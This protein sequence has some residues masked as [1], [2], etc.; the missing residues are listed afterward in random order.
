MDWAN[1]AKRPAAQARALASSL[2]VAFGFVSSFSACTS[3][4]VE[5]EF[6]AVVVPILEQRCA[7]AACHGVSA[8]EDRQGLDLHPELYLTFEL[9]SVGRIRDLD[10]AL[11][12]VKAKVDSTE[13][14]DFSSLLRKTLPV[15]QG[16]ILHFQ[17]A[18]FTSREDPEWM[19]LRDWVHS[20]TDGT[21]HADV[22]PLSNLELQ[23]RE[24]VYPTFVQKGC[25]LA[26]C[27]G[28]LNFGGAVLRAPAIPGTFSLPREAL[29][30]SYHEAVSNL[31][32]TGD[33]LRSRLLAKLLPLELGGI[34]HKGGND[35]FMASSTEERR[36]PRSA[37][38]V[39]AILQWAS[40]VRSKALSEV[41]AVSTTTTPAIVFVGGPIAPG[42][43]FSIDPFTPGTDLYRLEPPWS[44]D[45]AVNLTA[46]HHEGPADIR[47]PAVSHDGRSL[48]FTMRRSPEDAANLY[49]LGVD[50]SNLRQLT[51]D[52]AEDRGGLVNSNRSPVFGPTDG[53][54]FR[55]SGQRERIYFVSTR[56][57]Q[58]TDRGDIQ[59]WEL[60]AIDL[61]GSNLERLTFT[62]AAEVAPSFLATGE[63]FGTVVY[64]IQRAATGGL[65][66]ALFRFPIDHNGAHH[67]QPEA[68]PHFGTTGVNQVY[69]GLRELVDGRAVVTL[70]DEG[71]VWRGGQ[72]AV[73]DRQLAVDTPGGI[74]LPT[75]VPGFRHALSVLTP[76]AA[77]RGDSLGGLWRDP[78]PWPEGGFLAV[79][80]PGP[81]DLDQPAQRL[82]GALVRVELAEDRETLKPSVGRV[83]TL[84]PSSSE[85]SQPVVVTPRP[86]EDELHERVWDSGSEPA[87]LVHSGAQVI[88]A[89]LGH[90]PPVGARSLRD[91]LAQLRVV[92]PVSSLTVEAVPPEKT[93]SGRRG[94]TSAS[95]TGRTPLYAVGEVPLAPD[96]SCLVELP[97]R[98]PMRLA[99]LDRRGMSV[100]ADHHHWSAPKAK[101]RFPVG[102]ASF[103]YAARCA[104]C[105]GSMDGDPGQVLTPPVDI[106]TQASVTLARFEDHDRRRPLD[107]QH[108]NE[109]SSLHVDFRRDLEPILVTRCATVGCHAGASPAAGLSLTAAPTAFY[110]DAYES[111]LQHTGDTFLYVDALGQRARASALMERLLGAELDAPRR[112]SGV[113]PPPG[114]PGLSEAEQQAFARWIEL[115]AA[116]RGLPEGE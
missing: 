50:G 21:E 67:L 45:A 79:H 42:G 24:T 52:R 66:G 55:V 56:T 12:S 92:A 71:N 95:L 9:D 104:G 2:S 23:Y 57:R 17:R 4:S 11:A 83:T 115:G 80:V 73:L 82:R 108:V 40:A 26:T 75:S 36:D 100:G 6:E 38:E 61:D 88:E 25:V 29:R 44:P 93:R 16:G 31:A 60:F 46:A 58:W 15:V 32:P 112:L 96:G 97:A 84:L 54:H 65:R 103:A 3:A 62:P 78:S 87:V 89:L 10:A 94:A 5:A 35:V 105:H 72:L 90:L 59:D 53:T 77:R 110:T 18:V 69:L 14:P 109:G 41:G 81:L 76:E 98:V 101:E 19:T 114:H 99:F 70:L 106:L 7:S 33:L 34:P 107:P 20:V 22:P 43:P 64:T 27:H 30:A 74:D 1:N 113:C 111:L 102:I 37:P 49:T 86:F 28:E 85:V 39:Q 91:D 51:F 63:F 48:V 8:T 47:D 68:H 13:D 116:F